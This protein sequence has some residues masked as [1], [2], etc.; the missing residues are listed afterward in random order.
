MSPEIKT[1]LLEQQKWVREKLAEIQK[2]DPVLADSEPEPEIGTQSWKSTTHAEME[3]EKQGLLRLQK[4]TQEA[5]SLVEQGLYGKC[6]KCHRHV[7]EARLHS[8][9]TAAMC[10]SCATSQSTSAQYRQAA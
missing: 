3:V 8:P 9:V 5:M 1:R 6:K 2:N 4:H 7:E 10:A